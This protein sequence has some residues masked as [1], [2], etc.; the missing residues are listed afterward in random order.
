MAT[1]TAKPQRTC[2][3]IAL[4]AASQALSQKKHPVLIIECRV[5]E[6]NAAGEVRVVPKD[7]QIR[8]PQQLQQLWLTAGG[9]GLVCYKEV[10]AWRRLLRVHR[11]SLRLQRREMRRQERLVERIEDCYARRMLE[12]RTRGS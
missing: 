11:E 1:A 8:W 9:L 4:N 12:R 3:M 6:T 2:Y 10:E 7:P 5:T